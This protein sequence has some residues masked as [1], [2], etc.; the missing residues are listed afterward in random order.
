MICH[1]SILILILIKIGA[2]SPKR[3]LD[4]AISLFSITTMRPAK[5]TAIR[6]QYVICICGNT[7]D[8]ASTNSKCLLNF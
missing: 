8:T 4:G 5:I 1:C 3:S 7:D 2:F 6:H